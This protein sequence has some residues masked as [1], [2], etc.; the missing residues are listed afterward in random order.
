MTPKRIPP[1]YRSLHEWYCIHFQSWRT[2]RLLIW[3]ALDATSLLAEGGICIL[4][5]NKIMRKP[6]C[7]VENVKGLPLRSITL[8]KLKNTK[9]YLWISWIPSISLSSHFSYSSICTE[10]SWTRKNGFCTV[11]CKVI[12]RPCLRKMYPTHW[13]RSTVAQFVKFWWSRL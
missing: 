8:E 7:P 9:S 4:I 13:R 3:R 10:P 2:R 12:R 6:S 1:I 11:V 5:S